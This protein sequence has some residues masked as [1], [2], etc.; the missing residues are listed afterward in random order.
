MY[1]PITAPSLRELTS[2]QIDVALKS[3]PHEKP[4]GIL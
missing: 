3:L 2:L 4:L 1:T